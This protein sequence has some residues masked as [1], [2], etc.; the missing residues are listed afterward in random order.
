MKNGPIV[1]F[2]VPPSPPPTVIALM[3]IETKKL[4]FEQMDLDRH[5]KEI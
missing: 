4:K 1:K 5:V 3:E 2:G